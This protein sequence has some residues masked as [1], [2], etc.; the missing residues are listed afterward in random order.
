MWIFILCSIFGKI[1][2]LERQRKEQEEKEELERI[3]A[4]ERERQE[5]ERQAQEQGWLLKYL[6]PT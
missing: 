6:S 3:E 4:E 1:I 2:E 5:L